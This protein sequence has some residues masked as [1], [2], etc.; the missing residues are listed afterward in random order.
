VTTEDLI[1]WPT[2]PPPGV[3]LA[4]QEVRIA[5]VLVL[6]AK[7]LQESHGRQGTA[8]KVREEIFLVLQVC[9]LRRGPIGELPEEGERLMVELEEPVGVTIEGVVS[10][11]GIPRPG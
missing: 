5:G 4:A 7:G 3:P 2:K 8:L 10:P 6:P 11:P 9:G 1:R